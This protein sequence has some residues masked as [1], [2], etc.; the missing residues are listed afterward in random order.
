MAGGIPMARTAHHE[1]LP[2]NGS[3]TGPEIP[4]AAGCS[5]S[6]AARMNAA[7]SGQQPGVNP[8]PAAM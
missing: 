7:T 2:G 8:A 4:M 1:R 5:A 6:S 3:P